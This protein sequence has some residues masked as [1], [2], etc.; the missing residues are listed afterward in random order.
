MRRMII[1][2]AALMVTGFYSPS[3]IA[4]S[5]AGV[6]RKV[7]L[8]IGNASYPGISQLQNP[9]NDAE[10]VAG[11]LRQIGFTVTLLQNRTQRMQRSDLEEFSRKSENA[12]VVLFYYAG[13]GL[14]VDD[15]N[16]LVPV[17]VPLERVTAT[18]LKLNGDSIKLVES[19]LRRTRAKAIVM[20]IDACRNPPFRSNALAGLKK[21]PPVQGV[22]Q[23]YS[24]LPGARA[25]DGQPAKNSPFA[26]AFQHYAGRADM[27]I[28]QVA[29][30]IQNE[31]SN[32]TGASQ[33][34][35]VADGLAGDLVLASSEPIKTVRKIQRAIARTTLPM[36][37]SDNSSA[38]KDQR[39]HAAQASR[40]A[41]SPQLADREFEIERAVA[42]MDMP[43]L[44]VVLAR[45]QA[46][47]VIAATILG[48]LYMESGPLVQRDSRKAARYLFKAARLDFPIAMTYLGE[49]YAEGNG[50]PKDR[51]KAESYIAQSA[52]AGHVRAQ[53]TMITLKQKKG[54]TPGPQELIGAGQNALETM[55]REYHKAAETIQPPQFPN[56]ARH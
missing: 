4:D 26:V 30:H 13:H 23:I 25:L 34:P 21:N 42:S 54:N 49:M 10:L 27:P 19:Y 3:V 38:N 35:W 55:V 47:D 2:W 36:R 53:V 51:Q 37:G 28:S 8:V 46:G 33:I 41:W 31:V 29:K 1:G 7:A 52:Q 43:S 16:Y 44:E 12:D 56:S 40:M 20:V 6:A 39:L 9:I 32:V 18:E 15:V 5:D 48:R 22:I 11:T 45:D 14:A 24:T 50:V 17:D